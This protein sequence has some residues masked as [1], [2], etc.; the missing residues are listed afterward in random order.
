MIQIAS[1]TMRSN[2]SFA[3]GS[4][5][6]DSNQFVSR[7]RWLGLGL[8]T[9]P[10]LAASLGSGLLPQKSSAAETDP[11]ASDK[12]LGTRTYNIRN[13]GAKGDGATLDT[14]A[15]QSA[16][17]ACHLDQGGIVLVPAGVFVIGTTELKSN[18]TLHLAASAKLL[19][20]A[21]G[22]QYHAVDAIPLSGDTTLEDGN[23]AL[24]FAVKADNVTVEGN[25]TIDGQGLQF[26]S[27]VKGTPPPAGI[28]GA[29]RPYHLL[30]H[31]CTNLTVRD[32]FLKDCAFHSVRIIQ[33]SYVQLH[34]LHIHN[35]V[36][37]NN[38]GFHF[39][40][41]Q[42]VH[43]SNCD[44]Q[45]Q[46]DACALFGSCK[47]VTV[48]NCSFSTRWSVFRFGGGEAENIT[49]S[50]CL[51][52]QT[53]GCP[54]KLRCGPGSRFENMTCSNLVMQN[55]TGPISIGLGPRQRRRPA[56]A[57]AG[58]T[59][60]KTN[61]PPETSEEHPERPPGIVRNI[62]FN[63]IRATVVVP[64]P[65]P[66]CA[67]I[68][69]YNPGEMK[70]CI[71]LNG[72]G[73]AF[74]ENISFNDVHIT[75]AGG[76][77]AEEAAVR[78]VPTIVGEYYAAGVFPAYALYARNV[79]GLTLNNVRFELANPDARPAVVFDHVTD[80]AI[81]G[82]SVQGAKEAESVLRF[83]ETRD[84]LLTA[85]RVLTPAPVFL[86]TEGSTSAEIIID[87][88]DLSKAEKPLAFQ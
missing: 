74:L 47:F 8:A 77:T 87:G 40:S 44:V 50:N 61:T 80:A 30:F 68:S 38:D 78:D 16:I 37:H 54:I 63:N 3:Q 65:L 26:R 25:G 29:H 49:V 71:G 23:V 83:I 69:A 17:D 85:T 64:V 62:S 31:Q 58:A 22:K 76:G 18:V 52:Y 43:I 67:F 75:F 13:F 19:G 82:L 21:D 46:D 53:Y 9:T 81:N 7:R 70:S 41:S 59:D 66:D 24:L 6:I 11:A 56:A 55:V 73:D 5:M 4:P 36:N 15:L 28:S 48:T 14:A 57:A 33:S 42:Y 12:T 84:V 86:Q 1:S 88:G 27:P 35:R 60:I 79:R 72:V 10:V 51:I 20:S 2:N 34:G 32:I 45:C 39:I